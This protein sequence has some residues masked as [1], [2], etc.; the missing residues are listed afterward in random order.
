MKTIKIAA[1]ICAMCLLGPSRVE[2][3]EPCKKLHGATLEA[4]ISYLNT[5]LP[6]DG[7]GECLAYAITL[8]GRQRYEPAI[9][10]LAKLL[11]FRRP[12][13]ALEKNHVFLHAPTTDEIYPAAGA[14][15]EFGKASVP[16]VLSVMKS[17]SVSST[18]WENAVLVW[19]FVYRDKPTKGV[20]LLRQ[21]GC[22]GCRSCCE[23]EFKIGAR[24]RRHNVRPRR[25][26]TVYSSGGDE[27]TL[28]LVSCSDP[29]RTRKRHDRG[30]FR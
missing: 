23:G 19:M 2:A 22:S 21:E 17:T 18:A 28:S 20:A 11:G 8:L 1:L 30:P 16:A 3:E 12:A 6:N 27:G 14:L 25:E 26:S 10:A 7:N 4:L 9:P 15:E 13:T 24:E 29:L 5:A